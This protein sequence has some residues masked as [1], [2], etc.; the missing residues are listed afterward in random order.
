MFVLLGFVLFGGILLGV[1]VVDGA[2]A[3]IIVLKVSIIVLVVIFRCFRVVCSN[4][5]CDLMR[6]FFWVDR[7]LDYGNLG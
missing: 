6:E 1:L 3:R 7:Y 5:M 2:R 4:C